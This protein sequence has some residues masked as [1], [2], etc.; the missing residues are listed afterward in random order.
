MSVAE[1][2]APRYSLA[3]ECFRQERNVRQ[4]LHVQPHTTLLTLLK[5]KEHTWDQYVS[6]RPGGLFL[7]NNL[8][9]C[10]SIPIWLHLTCSERQL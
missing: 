5:Q 2:P 7:G 9:S 1:A 8:I 4:S 10:R 3:R 6:Y